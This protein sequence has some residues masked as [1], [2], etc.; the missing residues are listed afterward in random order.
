MEMRP[1]VAPA[2]DG[3]PLRLC[4]SSQPHGSAKRRE[5]D[6]GQRRDRAQQRARQS[7]LAVGHELQLLKNQKQQGGSPMENNSTA[8]ARPKPRPKNWLLI[9]FRAGHI[10]PRGG[11][12]AFLV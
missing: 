7:N 4:G 10:R 5:N 3:E 12:S 6:E 2:P 11:P 8:A 9:K 1:G